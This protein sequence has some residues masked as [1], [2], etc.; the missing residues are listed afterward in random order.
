ML[1]DAQPRA[2]IAFRHDAVP[3]SV[4]GARVRTDEHEVKRWCRLLQHAGIAADPDDLDLAVPPVLVPRRLRGATLDPSR[5]GERSAALA[6]R[7]AG[8][9]SRAPSSGSG[10]PSSSPAGPA[11]AESRARDRAPAPGVPSTHVFA[12]RT[13][14]RELAALVAAPGA[15]CAATP[16]SRISRR[17]YRRPSVVL[18][19]PIAAAR[20]GDRRR[21]RIIAC[22]GTVRPATR[23]RTASIPACS[24][25]PPERV[26]AALDALGA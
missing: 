14:L 13:N 19:G 7:N 22:S 17:A 24:P 21:A 5:R 26:I 18:F 10:A 2:L 3:Q 6:G 15:S 4:D 20:R 11:E 23:T 16:A 1:L 12:G 25:I 9:K 8:P